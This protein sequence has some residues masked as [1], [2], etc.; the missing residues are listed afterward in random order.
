ML[1]RAAFVD[2]RYVL[3]VSWREHGRTVCRAQPSGAVVIS[4]RYGQTPEPAGRKILAIPEL[5][6]G[7]LLVSDWACC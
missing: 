5:V 7:W 1:G 2:I 6:Q 3:T 4:P